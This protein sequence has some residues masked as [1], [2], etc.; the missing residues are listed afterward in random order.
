LDETSRTKAVKDLRRHSEQILEINDSFEQLLI[1][2]NALFSK[3][4]LNDI[5]EFSKYHISKGKSSSNMKS[6]ELFL[7][8]VSRIAPELFL[9]QIDNL[10]HKLV[11]SDNIGAG[12]NS[13]SSFTILIWSDVL[14]PISNL[15][16][17]DSE[18]FPTDL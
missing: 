1:R 12:K 16:K 18:K 7:Q 15:L 11:S 9:S 3:E 10:L 6:E 5:V 4:T 8:E 2:V 14:V 13:N 17:N